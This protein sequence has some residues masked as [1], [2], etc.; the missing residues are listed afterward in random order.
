MQYLERDHPP[1]TSVCVVSAGNLCSETPFSVGCRTGSDLYFIDAGSLLPLNKNETAQDRIT[2]RFLR[3][4]AFHEIRTGTCPSHVLVLVL[5][6]TL[7]IYSRKYPAF[8]V[9]YGILNLPVPSLPAFP[10]PYSS[11]R[12]PYKSVGVF[13]L[14]LGSLLVWFGFLLLLLLLLVGLSWQT[15]LAG[16]VSWEVGRSPVF[17]YS[18]LSGSHQL[19]PVLEPYETLLTGNVWFQ[20]C[21]QGSGTVVCTVN[22]KYQ[23]A[24]TCWGCQRRF[25]TSCMRSLVNRKISMPSTEVEVDKDIPCLFL[26]VCP[27][28][29]IITLF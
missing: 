11:L 24:L 29:S 2:V 9:V 6:P 17:G 12:H 1:D 10:S 5:K 22:Q 14:L 27:I 13:L 4:S 19:F 21:W 28:V 18:H 16:L 20:C 26:K 15:G 8:P 3:H 23:S 7:C 25:P